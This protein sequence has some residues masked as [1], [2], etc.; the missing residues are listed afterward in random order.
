MTHIFFKNNHY[1]YFIFLHMV[2]VIFPVILT[3]S[4]CILCICC[5]FIRF[6]QNYHLKPR[7]S[8]IRSKMNTSA[9]IN[10]PIVHN[11]AYTTAVITII[12]M[13]KNSDDSYLNIV[14]VLAK[15]KTG[16]LTVPIPLSS[17][18]LS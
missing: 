6:I 15:L 14:L 16:P 4:K 2:P 18:A 12:I 11:Q 9:T 7:S 1:F 10:Q 5:H 8:K 3:S 17:E 13:S